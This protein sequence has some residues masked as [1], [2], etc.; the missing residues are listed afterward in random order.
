LIRSILAKPKFELEVD[1]V[2][3]T[4]ELSGVPAVANAGGVATEFWPVSVTGALEVV[5]IAELMKL[6]K[7][8]KV[9]TA[10]L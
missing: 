8:A 3:L 10:S 4:V 2:R 5:V 1:V 7:D 6:Q 9:L